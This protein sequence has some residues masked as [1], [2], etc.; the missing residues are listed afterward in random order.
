MISFILFLIKLLRHI[1]LTVMNEAE[2]DIKNY[3]HPPWLQADTNYK[4][5]R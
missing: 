1:I 5:T 3:V 2:Y 4:T